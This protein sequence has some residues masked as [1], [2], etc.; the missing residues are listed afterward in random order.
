MRLDLGIQDRK[1]TLTIPTLGK[2]G[3]ANEYS[4]S[5]YIGFVPGFPT[6]GGTDLSLSDA[7]VVTAYVGYD[8][9][10]PMKN[11][12]LRIFGASGALPIWIDVANEI[13][14]N[15]RYQQPIDPLDFAFVS[16][17]NLSL[18]PPPGVTRVPVDAGSGLPLPLDQFLGSPQEG[19]TLY[20]YGKREENLFEPHRFFAPFVP[21]VDEIS[22][23]DHVDSTGD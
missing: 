13:V 22:Q 4:N 6:K 20:S 3:T 23:D 1:M 19:I 10:K 17:S 12:R 14:N 21:A 18:L 9:N 5:S 11:K 15:P 16:E 2:T 7:F 8:D